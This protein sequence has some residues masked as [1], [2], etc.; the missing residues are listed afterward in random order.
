MKNQTLPVQSPL[1]SRQPNDMTRS[2]V[3]VEHDAESAELHGAFPETAL[4][5]AEAWESNVDVDV[6]AA[7]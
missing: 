1:L 5:E 3:V 7:P 4:T 6:V 2:G